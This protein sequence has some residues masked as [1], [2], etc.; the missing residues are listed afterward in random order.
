MSIAWRLQPG[1]REGLIV[2]SGRMACQLASKP[3][4]YAG[5][6]DSVLVK[7]SVPYKFWNDGAA[8]LLVKGF[9]TP[10]DNYFCFLPEI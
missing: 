6:G 3:V 1:N 9:I 8:I 10:P 7:A 2:V 4:L 5:P